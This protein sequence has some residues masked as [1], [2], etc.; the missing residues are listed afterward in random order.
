[1]IPYLGGLE[2]L[3]L[4]W[5]TNLNSQEEWL[6]LSEEFLQAGSRSGE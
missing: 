4:Q 3:V 2:L 6:F 5:Y 1:L